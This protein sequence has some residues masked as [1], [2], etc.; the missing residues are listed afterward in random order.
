MKIQFK[1]HAGC[2]CFELEAETLEDA[3]LLARAAMNTTTVIADFK[4]GGE[5]TASVLFRKPKESRRRSFLSR[6][7]FAKN[8]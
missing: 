7:S 8:P 4:E 3:A 5:I 2:F 6:P 1:E